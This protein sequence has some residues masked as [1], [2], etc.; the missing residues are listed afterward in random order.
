MK[1]TRV[2]TPEGKEMKA[3]ACVKMLQKALDCN[4]ETCNPKPDACKML[5]KDTRNNM[6]KALGAEW[7]HICEL[8]T[9]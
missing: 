2:L 8:R 1:Y 5:C 7:H 6:G 9:L 4:P 3:P